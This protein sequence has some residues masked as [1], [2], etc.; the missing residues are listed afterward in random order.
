MQ[1]IEGYRIVLDEVG[2]VDQMYL[3]TIYEPEDAPPASAY[4]PAGRT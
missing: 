4:E 2:G 1:V 3:D